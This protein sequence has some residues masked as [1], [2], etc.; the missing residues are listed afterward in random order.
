MN[1]L[2]Q[3]RK[4]PAYLLSFSLMV[5]V[6][7]DAMSEI[8]SVLIDRDSSPGKLIVLGTGLDNAQFGLAGIS[9]PSSCVANDPVSSDIRQDILFCTET[10][11]AIPAEGSYNLTVNSTESFSIYIEKGIAAPPPPPVSYTCPCTSAWEAPQIPQDNS[12]WCEEGVDGTQEWRTTL[13]WLDSSGR[14]DVLSAA[15]DP[16]N[17]YFDP[18]NVSNSIS[19]CSLYD[20]NNYTTAEPIVNQEQYDDCYAKLLRDIC[21]W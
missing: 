3:Y 17:V 21:L 19:F 10:A 12:A 2:A 6:S 20:G 5:C 16:N 7:T 13:F 11:L 15:F 4:H 1:R 9:I 18:N 14:Q 8:H